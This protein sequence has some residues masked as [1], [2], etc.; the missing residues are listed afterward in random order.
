MPGQSFAG[1]FVQMLPENCV[2]NTTP[3]TFAGISGTTP[4]TDGSITATW[5]A[6]S[7]AG[8]DPIEYEIF[9][10]LGVVSAAALFLSTNK[11]TISPS[12]TLSKRIFTLADQ[13][14]YLVNGQQYTMGVRAVDSQ[15]Y[16]ETNTVIQT[17]TAIASGNLP[18]VY[19]TVATNLI[20]TEVLLAADHVNFQGDHTNFQSDHTNF[21][22][23]HTNFQTDHANFVAD[24]AALEAVSSSLAAGGGLGMTVEQ[25]ELFM[26]VTIEEVI[27]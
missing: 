10:A 13:T 18:V 14:T 1:N 19:Q 6:G 15:G 4:N 17:P 16:T 24:I 12:G 2:I 20:A 3:P 27:P 26:T 8:K 25:P 21:Q 23:D 9:I 22:G 5:A 11:V 7:T